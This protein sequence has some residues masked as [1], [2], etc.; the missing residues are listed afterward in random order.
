MSDNFFFFLTA[1]PW[2]QPYITGGGKKISGWPAG[3]Q[4][5][6]WQRIPTL[7]L[8]LVEEA[9]LQGW[10]SLNYRLDRGSSQAGLFPLWVPADG[11]SFC[12]FGL[13]GGIHQG[14]EAA[15]SSLHAL[16]FPSPYPGMGVLT[17]GRATGQSGWWQDGRLG[18]GLA[19]CV[20]LDT[21]PEFSGLQFSYLWNEEVSSKAVQCLSSKT[22][23]SKKPDLYPYP[24]EQRADSCSGWIGVRHGE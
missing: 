2:G 22:L 18:A 17:P 16:T 14:R 3:R 23:F 10:A 6:A 24:T 5:S 15:G 20:T 11:P 8:G 4:R 12:S 19:T 21:A 1:E 9:A 13:I 7:R